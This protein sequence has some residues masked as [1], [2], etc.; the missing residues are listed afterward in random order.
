MEEKRR[1]FQEFLCRFCL[2]LHG[3]Y[4][5]IGGNVERGWGYMHENV[6]R[7]G[8]E[9]EAGAMSGKLGF[10]PFFFFFFFN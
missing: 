8:R 7:K 3:L 9:R 10:C 2:G 6:K 5:Y 1:A 4:R